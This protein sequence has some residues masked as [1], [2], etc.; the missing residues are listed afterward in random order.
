MNITKDLEE[1]IEISEHNYLEVMTT[2]LSRAF[3]EYQQYLCVIQDVQAKIRSGARMKY[4][5]DGH[6]VWYEAHEKDH[7]GFK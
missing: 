7:I 4:L 6:K 2:Q 3:R 5:T 1:E